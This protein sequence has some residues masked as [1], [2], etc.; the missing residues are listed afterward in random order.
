MLSTYFC[1][2]EIQNVAIQYQNH[3][4]Y[5]GKFSYHYGNKLSQFCQSTGMISFEGLLGSNSM[6]YCTN[7]NFPASYNTVCVILALRTKCS[8]MISSKHPT[9][10]ANNRHNMLCFVNWSRKC[11]IQTYPL[12]NTASRSPARAGISMIKRNSMGFSFLW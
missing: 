2:T 9:L 6:K 7:K 12:L 4:R 5:S 1:V 3:M 8:D 10:I 11:F